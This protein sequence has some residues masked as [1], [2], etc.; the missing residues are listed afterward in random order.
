MAPTNEML[1]IALKDKPE[2]RIPD[3]E[4]DVYQQG[5]YQNFDFYVG[6]A[7]SRPHLKVS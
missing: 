3:N 7:L 2:L 1:N 6:V 5:E 4:P